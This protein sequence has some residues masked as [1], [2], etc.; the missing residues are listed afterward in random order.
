MIK[1]TILRSAYIMAR[2]RQ[3]RIDVKNKKIRKRKRDIGNYGSVVYNE[4]L[5]SAFS[6]Q[7]EGLFSKCHYG[8]LGSGIKTKTKN[9]YASYRHKGGYG[10]A[11]VYSKHDN[12][13][14]LYMKQALRE[15]GENV[16]L[17]DT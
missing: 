1:A 3:Y 2:T 12:V 4:K 10:K 17:F 7:K 11:C 9:A 5:K 8:A 15:Y 14:I 13:Q 16:L 6:G